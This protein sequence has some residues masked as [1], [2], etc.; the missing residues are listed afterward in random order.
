M[1]WVPTSGTLRKYL[2][3]TRVRTLRA[4]LGASA[5]APSMWRVTEAGGVF[6]PLAK[7]ATG[8]SRAIRI[9][10]YFIGLECPVMYFAESKKS[11]RLS[12]AG[13]NNNEVCDKLRKLASASEDQESCT[14]STEK[15]A[16][17]LGNHVPAHCCESYPIATFVTD[18]ADLV[19]V[20]ANDVVGDID[21]FFTGVDACD[22]EVDVEGLGSEEGNE[23]AFAG[24]H[25]ERVDDGAGVVGVGLTD[26]DNV[27]GCDFETDW[28]VADYVNDQWAGARINCG[29]GRNDEGIEVDGKCLRDCAGSERQGRNKGYFC[30]HVGGE[31]W[32]CW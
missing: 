12:P 7:A 15:G 14:E 2:S 1:S 8:V 26:F 18:G 3:P 27:A 25:L 19:F 11:R 32:G 31:E 10:R 20:R 28:A 6:L 24:I 13:P 21:G 4:N 5:A 22:I 9:I 17:W 29:S 23:D 16:A 30:F